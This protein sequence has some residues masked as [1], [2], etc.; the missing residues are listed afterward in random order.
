MQIPAM[1]S[2]NVNSLVATYFIY[3]YVY[4]Y[5]ADEGPAATDDNGKII[6]I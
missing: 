6:A 4:I 5:V 3:I 1:Y 2:H